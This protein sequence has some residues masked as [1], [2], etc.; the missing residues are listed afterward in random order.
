MACGWNHSLL[1]DGEGAVYSAGRGEQG[2]LGRGKPSSTGFEV[3]IRGARQ[4]SAGKDHSLVL[5]GAKVMGWGNSREGQLGL[6]AKKICFYPQE[7]NVY[8]ATFVFAG[9]KYSVFVTSK[10]VYGTGLNQNCQLGLGHDSDIHVPRR[11]AI[12][13]EI[14]SVSGGNYCTARTASN[15]WYLW[16]SGGFGVFKYPT[17]MSF[18]SG[19]ESV[20]MGLNFG[21]LS[22]KGQVWV[23][24]NNRWGELGSGEQC[25]DYAV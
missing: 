13:E 25:R 20:V 1:L 22:K 23:W 14:L 11:L 2:E 9:T 17:K 6:L 18:L 5:C 12:E 15:E 21:L 3:V 8:P 19:G 4:V 16:G 10:G 7:L 24:G